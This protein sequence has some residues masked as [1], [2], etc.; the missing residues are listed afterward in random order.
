MNLGNL[1]TNGMGSHRVD[2]AEWVFKCRGQLKFWK[3]NL[4]YGSLMDAIFMILPSFLLFSGSGLWWELHRHG[5]RA[6][7]SSFVWSFQSQQTVCLSHH[8]SP[9]RTNSYQLHPCGAGEPDG[10]F[11]HL[12]R[13][14]LS[15]RYPWG[16]L[17]TVSMLCRVVVFKWLLNQVHLEHQRACQKCLPLLARHY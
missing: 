4:M 10:L 14:N 7:P 5:W 15:T 12:H 6:P 9:G 13:G 16:V 1:V 3:L 2:R 11:S 17:I 8:P